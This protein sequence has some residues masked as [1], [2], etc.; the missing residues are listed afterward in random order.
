MR[1]LCAAPPVDW[2]STYRS[3]HDY[4]LDAIMTRCVA[5]P[6]SSGQVSA[7]S[8]ARSVYYDG[9]G[10]GPA[11]LMLAPV[12]ID[13][14]YFGNLAAELMCDHRVVVWVESESHTNS[15][16]GGDA[17]GDAERGRSR[18]A[19]VRQVLDDA[20]IPSC[21]VVG[22]CV[23]VEVVSALIRECP[24]RIESIALFSPDI[25]GGLSPTREYKS[26]IDLFTLIAGSPG[27]AEAIVARARRILKMTAAGDA[28]QYRSGLVSPLQYRSAAL[29][30]RA[31]RVF[32]APAH[33][34]RW[35]RQFLDMVCQA[36]STTA[37][38]GLH[39]Y[40]GPVMTI[41]GTHDSL[42]EWTALEQRCEGFAH[43]TIVTIRGG[44]HYVLTEHAPLAGEL[45][46]RFIRDGELT[47]AG[48]LIDG[49]RVAMTPSPQYS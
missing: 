48:P 35:A 33:V 24:S 36:G 16:D 14:G 43:G 39:S 44:N 10:D 34:V 7:R 26:L 29:A 47:P 19:D 17:P 13:P 18:S 40:S 41:L 38:P 3:S 31:V 6:A 32:D 23:G 12:G 28:E 1:D 4:D 37:D 49:G 22:W 30:R 20:G 46:R 5:G 21:H 27:D 8:G 45:L 9:G 15:E 25:G 42:L 2:E 11:V